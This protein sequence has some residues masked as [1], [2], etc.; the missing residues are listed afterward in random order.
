MIIKNAE[1][2]P[3]RER[4]DK[5]VLGYY[6]ALDELEKL[7]IRKAKVTEEVIKRL[8]ALVMA[9]GKK[10][11]KPSPYRDGQNVIRDSRTNKIVYL[12][13]E[14]KDV[15]HLMRDLV[16]W[17][18][19]TEHAH[20]PYPLLAGIAHYQFAT[21][22]PYYDG[23]GR[24]ARLLTTLILHKGA[25]DLKGI[26]LNRNFGFPIHQPYSA[27]LIPLAAL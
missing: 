23:N 3:G 4:D 10:A 21:I 24:T 18:N 1:H 13:P 17:F 14:A 25:Y 7:A 27:K 19:A 5:E 9:G 12:P 16:L 15:P 8:H 11:A 26:Y 2:I 20:F 6:S 22:H